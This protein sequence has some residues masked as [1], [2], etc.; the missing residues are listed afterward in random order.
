MKDL[1]EENE[2]VKR[3]AEEYQQKTELLLSDNL[4]LTS[5]LTDFERTTTPSDMSTSILQK[6]G[7]YTPVS[8][9]SRILRHYFVYIIL[10]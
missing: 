1:T 8:E 2:Q 4:N 9:V 7:R 6:Q 3:Q 10:L 5:R